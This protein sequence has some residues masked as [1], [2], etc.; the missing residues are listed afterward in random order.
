MKPIN[1]RT[2][3][4]LSIETEYIGQ[5]IKAIKPSG[6]GRKIDFLNSLSTN[7]DTTKIVI[8]IN[9][10]LKGE[11]FDAKKKQDAAKN[12]VFKKLQDLKPFIVMKDVKSSMS[13]YLEDINLR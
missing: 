8:T 9:Q 3:F 1:F 11:G 10:P 2:E 4:R 12:F 13:F 5:V 6:I 7:K